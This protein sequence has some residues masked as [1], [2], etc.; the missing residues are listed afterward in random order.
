MSVVGY[1]DYRAYLR[2]VLTARLRDNARY[3]LRAFAR[4]LKLPPGRLSEVLNRKKGLSLGAAAS[5]SQRLS[6]SEEEANYFCDLV[7]IADSRSDSAR[8]IA[9]QRLERFKGDTEYHEL[10]AD[11]FKVIADWYHFAILELSLVEGFKSDATWIGRKLGISSIE[12]RSAIERLLRL[13]LFEKSG[14]RLK[15]SGAG[16]TTTNGIPSTAIRQF[17]RQILAKAAQAIEEQSVDERDFSTITMPINSKKLGEAKKKISAFRRELSEYLEEGK[18]DQV[19]T[20]AIQLFRLT[21]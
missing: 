1:Q 18:A 8:Q 9:Q 5:I 21:Q 11:V 16:L 13:G 12:A 4:D 6:L 2:D 19:Y 3:S 17:N 7:Q 14:S 20:L 15:K 10:E